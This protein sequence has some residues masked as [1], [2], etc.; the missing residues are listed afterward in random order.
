MRPCVDYRELN[1]VTKKV[2]YPLPRIDDTLD[3]LAPA[4]WF[5]TLDLT[6]GYW[7]I[8]IRAEDREK[9]AFVTNSQ[10][11]PRHLEFN[12]LPFGLTNAPA[13]FQC[14]MDHVLRGLIGKSALVYMDDILIYS[15]TF[16][17]HLRDIQLV[18][19]RLRQ[20][21]MVAK[22]G[23]CHFCCRS[24]HYLGHV[25]SAEGIQPDPAKI[26]AVRDAVGRGTLLAYGAS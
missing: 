19:D 16:E 4:R 25:V 10:V 9:T 2:A 24:V 3:S 8:P 18:F 7:Q 15:R 20:A 13:T 23:K 6:S 12:V 26:Q 5:T 17:D 14:Y 11:H 22:I 21:N 1:K